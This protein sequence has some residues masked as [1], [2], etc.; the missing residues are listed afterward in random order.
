MGSSKYYASSKHSY[1]GGPKLIPG[2]RLEPLNRS[3]NVGPGQCK[4]IFKNR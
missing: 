4:N 1:A 2:K 3:L